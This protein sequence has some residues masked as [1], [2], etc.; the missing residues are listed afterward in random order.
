MSVEKERPEEMKKAMT[1]GY[2][3]KKRVKSHDLCPVTASA[4]SMI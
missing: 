2:V 3:C 4:F 1:N